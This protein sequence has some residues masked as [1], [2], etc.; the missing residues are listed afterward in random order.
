MVMS[1]ISKFADFAKTQKSRYI[2]NETLFFLQMKKNN[3][4]EGYFMVKNT[5]VEEVPF[6]VNICL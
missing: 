5:F 1:Q 3:N 6:K 2:K 4:I